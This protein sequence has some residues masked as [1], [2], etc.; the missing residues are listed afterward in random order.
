[1]KSSTFVRLVL[2]T[3][4]SVQALSSLSAQNWGNFDALLSQM[5]SAQRASYLEHLSTLQNITN[6]STYNFN[7][8]LDSLNQAVNGTNPANSSLL[9]PSDSLMDIYVNA[10]LAS[11]N[12]TPADSV[13]FLNEY[14]VVG[15]VWNSEMDSLYHSFDS[16]QNQINNLPS[17]P[18]TYPN[19]NDWQINM[20][21]LT[22]SQNAAFLTI[23]AQGLG[24]LDAVLDQLFDPAVFNRF[25]IF[26]GLQQ[27]KTA[28]YGLFEQIS[29]PV[30]GMRS[31]EQ[32]NKSWEPR[33]RLQSSW[34]N[35][36]TGVIN[37]E[38][39]AQENKG[40]SPFIINGGF[41]LMYN[42]TII[43]GVNGI[44]VRLITLLGVE[45]G[46]YAPAH[47]DPSNART[48]NNKGYTTGWGPVIGTGLSTRVGNVT[49]YA[50]GTV[51]YGDVVCGPDAMVSNYRFRSNRLESGVLFANAVTVRYENQLSANWANDGNKHVRYQQ[52]TVGLPTNGLFR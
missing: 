47:R 39:I 46:T 8:T 18:N 32:F 51:A 6:H 9:F 2:L 44:P 22:S 7:S 15:Q 36:P 1:M 43:P 34:L 19:A 31:V 33:W 45:A 23:P 3:F 4:F 49:I 24:G 37:N 17:L 16:Y 52:V 25:E 14:G 26:S 5:D 13:S 50:L 20:G 12:N 27:A 35:N 41:D 48:M 40:I 30:F 29:A 21:T 11:S 38:T 28:Y 42:P 10:I